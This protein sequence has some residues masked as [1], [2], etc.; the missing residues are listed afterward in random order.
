MAFEWERGEYRDALNHNPTLCLNHNMQ[1]NLM[2]G[3]TCTMCGET[4]N[5]AEL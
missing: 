2:G 4:V 3:G 1:P 5:A